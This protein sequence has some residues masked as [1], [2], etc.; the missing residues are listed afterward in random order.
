MRRGHAYAGTPPWRLNQIKVR[1]ENAVIQP[2]QTCPALPD[3]QGTPFR[4]NAIN[5]CMLLDICLR[6]GKYST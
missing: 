6:F 5:I 1:T 4:A 3:F 2:S